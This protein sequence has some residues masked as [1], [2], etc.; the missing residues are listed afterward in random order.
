ML[1]D[2]GHSFEKYG[3]DIEKVIEIE[4]NIKEYI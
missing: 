4:N 2:Y 1:I 3:D